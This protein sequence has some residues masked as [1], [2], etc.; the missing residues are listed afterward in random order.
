MAYPF[1]LPLSVAKSI[2]YLSDDKFTPIL[3]S[4]GSNS[5]APSTSLSNSGISGISL[6]I[7]Y[8]HFGFS[9]IEALPDKASNLVV[10]GLLPFTGP[11]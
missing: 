8:I 7:T 11:T 1:T 10:P 4:L 6:E 9:P 2:R 3:L 5:L